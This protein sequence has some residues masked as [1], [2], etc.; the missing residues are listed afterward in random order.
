MSK[1]GIQELKEFLE[2]KISQLKRELEF[3]ELLLSIIESGKNNP[4]IRGPR[5]GEEVLEVKDN[6]GSIIAYIFTGKEYLRIVPI[7]EIETSNPYFE[8]LIRYLEEQKRKD[9][10]AAKRGEI[11]ENKILDYEVIAENGIVRE[12]VVRNTRKSKFFLVELKAAVVYSFEK[13]QQQITA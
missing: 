7:N 9:I 3:Y 1:N 10:E 11:P 2:E 8:F 12:I 6:T 13:A 5:K 4:F